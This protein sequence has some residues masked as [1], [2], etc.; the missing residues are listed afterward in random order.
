MKNHLIK[1]ARFSA[2]MA[3]PPS[4]RSSRHYRRL[5]SAIV[6]HNEIYSAAYFASDVE[7]AAVKSARPMASSIVSLCKPATV[8]D[9]GCGTGALLSA[10]RELGCSVN[11]LEY[12]EGGLAYCRARGLNVAKFDIEHDS[13]SS[14]QLTKKYD[15]VTSF[16]VAEHLPARHADRFTALLASL[17]P[18]IVMSAAP[19]GQGG[20]DHVNE[21]P[22][23]YWIDKF[24]RRGRSYDEAMSKRLADDWAAA[25]VAP[26]YYGNVMVFRSG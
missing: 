9:V 14:A 23:S 11:G 8:I 20:T 24:K 16:E 4:V 22:R 26:F 7:G 21:Q 19:P 5:V 10:F 17:S 2:K 12:A 13:V 15:V 6:P 25:N 1:I 18:L 3:L